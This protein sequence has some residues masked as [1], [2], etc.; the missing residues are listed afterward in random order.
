MRFVLG[1]G[2]KVVPY[3]LKY[4]DVMWRQIG[5]NTKEATKGTTR[6][7]RMMMSAFMVLLLLQEDCEEY[8]V[9]RG[10]VTP[11]LH[12]CQGLVGELNS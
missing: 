12:W 3:F 2:I 9:G 4:L 8:K 6:I 10:I 11:L 7:R 5:V 1:E